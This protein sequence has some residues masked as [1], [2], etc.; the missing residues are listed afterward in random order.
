MAHPQ[1]HP[2]AGRCVAVESCPGRTGSRSSQRREG[3]SPSSVVEE[4]DSLAASVP[5]LPSVADAGI[6]DPA[7]AAGGGRPDDRRDRACVPVPEAD[8]GAADQP[9]KGAHPRVGRAL[10]HAGARRARGAPALGAPRPVPGLQ[11]GLHLER[12]SSLQRVELSDEA[13]RLRACSSLR[14]RGR[15]GRGAPGAHAPDRCATGR[16]ARRRCDL[17]P[18]PEQDRSP[19]I[20]VASWRAWRCWSA[21][22]AGPLGEYGVQAAIAAVH[23]EAASAD[24]TDWPRIV[25]LYERLEEMTGNPVVTVNRAVAVAMVDGPA[26]GLALLDAGRRPART[27]PSAR[28]GARTSPGDGGGARR[29][30]RALP[31]GGAAG[32]I[33]SRAPLPRDAG[34]AP[35]YTRGDR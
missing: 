21:R 35:G 13:I 17:V 33:G 24:E 16:P 15:R 23:D 29:G 7:D 11:R 22:P 5:V 1:R 10:R 6:R 20:A 30:D 4:D 26:A 34:G 19:G 18:L 31:G 9:G 14:A 32:D 25:A 12:R 8:D 28:C 2:P 27:E 3:T